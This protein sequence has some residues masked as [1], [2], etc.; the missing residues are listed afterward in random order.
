MRRINLCSYKNNGRK[1]FELW[2]EAFEMHKLPRH[3][4]HVANHLRIAAGPTFPMQKSKQMSRKGFADLAHRERCQTAYG[5]GR[6]ASATAAAKAASLG[7]LPANLNMP[8]LKKCFNNT[9]LFKSLGLASS[10]VSSKASRRT[11]SG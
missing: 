11:I 4:T 6:R 8:A 7:H 3:Q 5:A 1:C 10:K 2:G 9:A